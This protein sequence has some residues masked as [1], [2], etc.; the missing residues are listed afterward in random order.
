MQY[1]P[2]NVERPSKLGLS[3]E[4]PL[5]ELLCSNNLRSRFT[6]NTPIRIGII[7]HI[8]QPRH[9]LGVLNT[10]QVQVVYAVDGWNVEALQ[11]INRFIRFLL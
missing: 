9:R 2:V 11:H 10:V 7:L 6:R 5:V 3:P 8:I 1:H 4:S